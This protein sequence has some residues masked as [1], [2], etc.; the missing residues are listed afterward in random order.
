MVFEDWLIN[1]SGFGK[2]RGIYQLFVKQDT[3]SAETM[4]IAK[5]TDNLVMVGRRIE[6]EVLAE[7]LGR[8]FLISRS[9]IDDKIRLNG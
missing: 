3:N 6:L 4:V 1:G 8:R 7:L 9:E 5:V 2:I